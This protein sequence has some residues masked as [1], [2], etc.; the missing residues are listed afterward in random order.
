MSL[1]KSQKRFPAC[2]RCRTQKLKCLRSEREQDL[3][4]KRCS[5]AGV[6]CITSNRRH[7]GR[8]PARADSQLV[9]TGRASWP[10]SEV[11]QHY[12]YPDN[13]HQH[14][15]NHLL[16][17]DVHTLSNILGEFNSS[18]E[19]PLHTFDAESLLDPFIWH[20]LSPLP[21]TRNSP[22]EHARAL[23]NSSHNGQ[24]DDAQIRLSSLQHKLST[25][26]A[27]CKALDW[28]IRKSLDL[29]CPCS[30]DSRPDPPPGDHLAEIFELMEELQGLLT[31]IGAKKRSDSSGPANQPWNSRVTLTL[32]AV[33]CYL[34]VCSL[35]DCIFSRVLGQS[36]HEPSI[37]DLMLNP[38]LRFSMAGTI[39]ITEQN[40]VGRLFVKLMVTKILPIETVLGIP[41]KLRISEET[42]IEAQE[43]PIQYLDEDKMEALLKTLQELDPPE[44][45]LE[46]E[47][48]ISNTVKHKMRRILEMA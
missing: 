44:C 25:K 27:Q 8:P 4:C 47:Y 19:Y 41:S 48:S 37:K 15:N 14:D 22:T 46:G 21:S 35:Y 17:D 2:D 13:L 43:M 24:S 16:L 6:L 18:P 36:S 10:S 29:K 33:S 32:I 39:V 3:S 11:A 31:H 40:M 28:D 20:P 23:Q 30:T 5:Q 9:S 26:L 12:D 42:S 7:P 45:R 34:H 38:P 1:A